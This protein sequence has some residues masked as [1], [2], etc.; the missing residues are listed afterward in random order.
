LF[1]IGAGTSSTDR[2][3]A[4]EVKQNGDVYILIDETPCKMEMITD[5]E[6]K[7]LFK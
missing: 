5:D 2:K 7:L 3:N 1:S 4:I 6:I